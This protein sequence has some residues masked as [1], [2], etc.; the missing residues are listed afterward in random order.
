[1]DI[2]DV[3]KTLQMFADTLTIILGALALYGLIAKRKKLSSFINVVLNS[4]LNERVRRIRDTVT[5]LQSISLDDASRYKEGIALLGSLSGQLKP[6]T[7]ARP[8]LQN[9]HEDLI[10]MTEGKTR[11]KESKKNAVIHEISAL[12]DEVALSGYIGLLSEGSN[13]ER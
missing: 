2:D 5:Q 13:N 1:M 10:F 3:A 12:L 11:V 7:T 9:L 8:R 4:H 6:L